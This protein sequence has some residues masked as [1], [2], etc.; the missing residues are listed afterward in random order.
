MM[1]DVNHDLRKRKVF[2]WLGL[3]GGRRKYW[4]GLLL[5]TKMGLGLCMFGRGYTNIPIK[6]SLP[7][8]YHRKLRYVGIQYLPCN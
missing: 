1:K 3:L 6:N 7:A 8:V 5:V 2:N 4:G